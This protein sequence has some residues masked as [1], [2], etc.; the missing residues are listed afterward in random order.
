MLLK[1]FS[2][3]KDIFS[4]YAESLA[5]ELNALL[6]PENIKTD[7]ILQKASISK[8]TAATEK[9]MEKLRFFIKENKISFYRKAKMANCF[10]WKLKELGHSEDFVNAM[11]EIFAM[12]ISKQTHTSSQGDK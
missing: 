2:G 3:R 9:T 5:I 8:A 11:T 7:R 4:A 10:K 6:P 1:F 12:E